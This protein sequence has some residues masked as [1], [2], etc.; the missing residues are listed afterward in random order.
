MSLLEDGLSYARNE[1]EKS[2]NRIL[3]KYR[4]QLRQATD[5]QVLYKL[6]TT[7]GEAYEITLKEAQRRNLV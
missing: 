7:Q 1:M 5:N 4:K 6:S 3:D 2:V